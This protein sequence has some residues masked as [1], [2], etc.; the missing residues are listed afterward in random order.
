MWRYKS[1]LVALLLI[2]N[3]YR[4]RY[5]VSGVPQKSEGSFF[6]WCDQGSKPL[7]LGQMDNWYN[8]KISENKDFKQC[9]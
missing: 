8:N 9:W 4:I 5:I 3:L 2:Y 6:M 1:I 7:L